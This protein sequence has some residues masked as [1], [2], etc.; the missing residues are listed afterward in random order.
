MAESV[1]SKLGLQAYPRLPLPSPTQAPWLEGEVHLN[2]Q[3][4][5]DGRSG[6]ETPAAERLQDALNTIRAYSRLDFIIYTDGSV[7]SGVKHGGCL[8]DYLE[9]PGR[10][11]FS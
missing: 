10:P 9:R 6:R 1:V 2:V 4:R 7:L 3:L 5:L 11:H 8:A